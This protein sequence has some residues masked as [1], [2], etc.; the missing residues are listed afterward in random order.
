MIILEL[1]AKK[2]ILLELV[3]DDTAE[4]ARAWLDPIAKSLNLD[5]AVF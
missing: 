3:D 5:L 2:R 4:T 1:N